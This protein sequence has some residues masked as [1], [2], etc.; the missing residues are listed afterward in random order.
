[1]LFLD[2]IGDLPLSAQAKPLRALQDGE[3]YRVGATQ[4]V[5]VDVRVIAATHQDLWA[6]VNEG[7]FREDLFTG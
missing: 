1:M 4:P 2:E 6:R 3:V 7:A 5:K